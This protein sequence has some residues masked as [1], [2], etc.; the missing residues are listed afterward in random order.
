MT[1]SK[2]GVDSYLRL[3]CCQNNL[4]EV[5]VAFWVNTTDKANFGTPLS[6]ATTEND[7]ELSITDYNGFALYVHG[8]NKVT[9]VQAADGRWHHIAVTWS[10]PHGHWEIYKDGVLQDEGDG[11]AKG[12][13]IEG[14]LTN[15]LCFDTLL[16]F[17]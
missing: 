8:E 12:T 14:N 17:K 10:S 4:S 6:Y 15:K 7:N 16:P 11:L 1:W 9:D 5:T 13:Y 2:G 3:D